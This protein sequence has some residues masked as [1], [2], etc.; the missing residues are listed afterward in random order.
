MSTAHY[1]FC[2]YCGTSLQI[3]PVFAKPRAVCPNCSF[4]HFTDPKVAAGVL[5]EQNGSVLLVRRINEPQQGLWSLP[6]GFIDA[7]EDPREA[8]IREC[9][10]E[11]GLEVNITELVEVVAGREHNRGADIVIIYGAVVTGGT[12][13]PGDDSD[14]AVFFPRNQLPPLAFHATR[15]VLGVRE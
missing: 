10:E 3:K 5:V 13:H 9:R 15:L 7:G 1:R 12:L 11:T 14:Q 6:A 2:P 8:A 4:I